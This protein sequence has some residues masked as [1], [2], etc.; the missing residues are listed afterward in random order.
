MRMVYR[1]DSPTWI[2]SG[3][4]TPGGTV[5]IALLLKKPTAGAVAYALDKK[6]DVRA[7]M[8]HY[9][10]RTNEWYW[11]NAGVPF[12]YSDGTTVSQQASQMVTMMRVAYVIKF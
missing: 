10:Y 2:G 4:S 7:D 9:R 8:M 12:F 11:S 6:T 1:V 3:S 5:T